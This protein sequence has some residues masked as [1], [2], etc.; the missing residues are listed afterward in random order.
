MSAHIAYTDELRHTAAELVDLLRRSTLVER[1]QRGEG[2]NR[3][4]ELSPVL[5]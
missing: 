1:G 5:H 3:E 4:A 2:G